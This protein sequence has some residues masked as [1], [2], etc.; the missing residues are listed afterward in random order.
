MKVKSYRCLI[1]EWQRQWSSPR[2]YKTRDENEHQNGRQTFALIPS[3]ENRLQAHNFIPDHYLTMFLS[4]HGQCQYY[5]WKYLKTATSP[6]CDCGAP[7][8]T[9]QH[10][11]VECSR[12]DDLRSEL[13]S[14]NHLLLN[15]SKPMP[16][17][18]E[19]MVGKEQ[20]GRCQEGRLRFNIAPTRSLV[21]FVPE[22]RM[23]VKDSSKTVGHNQQCG[24]STAKSG[25]TLT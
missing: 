21:S 7:Q 22:V 9:M 8:Q 6:S 20:K 10:I 12:F 25:R 18:N 14:V 4:G 19:Q 2:T 24:R 11:E 1:S 17:N 13:P 5:Y 16:A 15:T 3:I 23:T